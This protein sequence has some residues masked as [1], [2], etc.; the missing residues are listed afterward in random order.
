MVYDITA[1]TGTV[2]VA[3]QVIPAYQ[4]NAAAV[5]EGKQTMGDRADLL[6]LIIMHSRVFTNLQNQNLIAYIP[7]A[8]GIINIPTYLGYHVL[9]S[10]TVP[11][12]VSGSDLIYTTYLCGSGIVGFTE[13]PPMIPVETFRYP[14][15]GNGA[16][17]E[18][19]FTRRQFAMHTYG[20]NW[21]DASCAAEFP[22]NAE[23]ETAANWTRAYPE[24]KQIA[25]A[26]VKTK[27]G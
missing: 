8:S 24:R 18:A 4:M 20:F 22:T 19:L 23:I 26:V 3:G 17:V 1:R 14:N 9:V 16:G 27:N 13:K 21:T 5:L 11:V 10:D 2:T 6:K 7:N 25:L 15:Q 12:T